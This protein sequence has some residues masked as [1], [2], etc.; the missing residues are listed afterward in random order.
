MVGLGFGV[1]DDGEIS[2]R[3][4]LA[5][6]LDSGDM[7]KDSEA[8]A[9]LFPQHELELGLPL[10]CVFP[11]EIDAG[12]FTEQ[13]SDHFE[14]K[15]SRR[16]F[17]R[18]K[19]DKFVNYRA[20]RPSFFFDGENY[21][22]Y[23]PPKLNLS[24]Y[25]DEVGRKFFVLLGFEPDFGWERFVAEVTLIVRELA[26]EEVLIFQSIPFPVPHTR[27][28]GMAVTGNRPD[29]IERFASWKPRGEVP[30]TIASLLEYRLIRSGCDVI[31]FVMLTPHYLAENDVPQVPLKML[32][33]IGAVTGLVIPSDALRARV[34]GFFNF[35]TVLIQ[36]NP[37]L[38][39]MIQVM[40]LGYD[41]G[42]FS[43]LRDPNKAKSTPL[44]ADEIAADLEEYLARFALN[45]EQNP[46]DSGPAKN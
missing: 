10:I 3:P 24:L 7:L 27:E 12:G 17:A 30:T 19:P 28:I 35:V 14:T 33:V 43:P 15:L 31:G 13:I 23:S 8:V 42:K 46:P 6:R 22:K 34:P 44:S 9:Y 32:E 29:I 25:Q 21:R 38:A 20:H 11:G 4:R 36:R 26:I 2:H 41:Q 5:E 16:N 1:T 45:E 37:E 39:K 40:E 18:F